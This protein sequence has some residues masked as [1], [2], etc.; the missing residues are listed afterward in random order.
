M[1]NKIDKICI[2]Q[3]DPPVSQYSFLDTKQNIVSKAQ[4]YNFTP[5]WKEGNVPA[6]LSEVAWRIVAHNEIQNYKSRAPG[7]PCLQVVRI[8]FLLRSN[9]VNYLSKLSLMG[10]NYQS[11]SIKSRY[12]IM[13]SW[14]ECEMWGPAYILPK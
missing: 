13:K 2:G 3:T 4:F 10:Q 9:V 6:V 11:Q 5:G 8:M 12:S 14:K 1:V 7:P